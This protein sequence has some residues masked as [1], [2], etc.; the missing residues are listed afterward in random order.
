MASMVA[1]PYFFSVA[2]PATTLRMV[3]QIMPMTQ[4]KGICQATGMHPNMTICAGIQNIRF[5]FQQGKKLTLARAKISF[6]FKPWRY[7]VKEKKM[8]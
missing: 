5:F 2:F 8:G 1:R 7:P 6:G 3:D 4:A